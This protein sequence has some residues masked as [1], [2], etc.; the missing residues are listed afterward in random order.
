MFMIVMGFNS[1]RYNSDVICRS[2]SVPFCLVSIPRGTIQIF[3]QL[4]IK[5][6]QLKFQFQEVQFRF[7]ISGTP[8]DP[9]PSF[10]SK[11]YNSDFID[12]FASAKLPQ[13]SIPR[14]TIQIFWQMLKPYTQKRF[15]FQEVQFRFHA[16]KGYPS[17]ATFQFQEVQF[18]FQSRHLR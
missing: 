6:L 12:I 17:G 16:P 9:V 11:R 5:A 13:V 2:N 8:S 15:Q 3:K 7:T 18:R 4:T 1:K 14:G 10:N